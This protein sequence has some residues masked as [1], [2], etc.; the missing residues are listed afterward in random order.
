MRLSLPQ[1]WLRVETHLT[2]SASLTPRT[3][4]PELLHFSIRPRHR[5]KTE[6]IL[7]AFVNAR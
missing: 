7:R 1:K 5:A 6:R 4:D 2:L 3:L